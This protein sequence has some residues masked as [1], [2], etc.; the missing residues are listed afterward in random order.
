MTLTRSARRKRRKGGRIRRLVLWGLAFVLLA[1]VLL[2]VL[3]SVVPP[4]STLMVSRYVTLQ[5]VARTYVPLEA[6]S[7]HLQRAVVVSED[8]LYC[9]HGGV[10]WQAMHKQVESLLEGERARGASTI[11][12][13]TA[14]NLFLW[15]GRN[16]LRKAMETPLAI[17]LDA[18]LTK[19]RLL[20]IY[21]NIVE[22][23]DGIFGA[24]AAAQAYFGKSAKDLTRR[25]AALLATALPNPILRNPARPGAGHQRLASIN[26]QR[27]KVAGD[28][29]ACMS[30]E[31]Q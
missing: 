9:E 22:W 29:I 14:K 26:Q 4:I 31:R 25:E 19:R 23:G 10:D 6:V 7:E 2:T 12:M 5:P 1:P 8:S 21:L 11:P 30:A 15:N 3:Y 20:E 24:E 18:M 16:Y 28:V 17:M 27:M 13:Q